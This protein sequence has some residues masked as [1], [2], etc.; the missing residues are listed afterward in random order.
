MEKI[1]INTPTIQLDQFLK[2]AGVLQSGGEIKI[3]L[4]EQR[5]KRNGVIE[6]AKRRKLV[7]GDVIEIEGA[8]TYTVAADDSSV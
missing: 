8:G 4:E 1:K 7:P 6:T 5:I 3:L 2:W